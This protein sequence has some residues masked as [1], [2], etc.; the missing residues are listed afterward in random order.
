[1][2]N[3]ITCGMGKHPVYLWTLPM[4]HCNGWCFPWTLSVVAGT[5]VCLRAVRAAPIYDAIA[6]HKVTHLCGAPIVMSTLLNAPEH[7][8]KPLPHVVEFV[9]A[10]A[11][12][13][14]AVLAAMKSAGFNV[15][16]VYGLTEVYGP[17]SVNDWHREWNALSG[18]GAGREEGAPGRALSGARSARRAR[19][20][21]PC[22]RC[23]ATARRSAK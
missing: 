12:P 4:F 3:V 16:H 2:A 6:T 13:P 18:A 21:R 5:H 7:E 19:S 11:P 22:S 17:A 9:T 23:R 20:R 10:A 8:Q 1:M 15:T 14:E